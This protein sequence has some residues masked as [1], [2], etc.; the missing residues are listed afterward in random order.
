MPRSNS[1]S[2]LTKKK[3]TTQKRLCQD[4]E[5]RRFACTV[6]GCSKRFTTSGHLQRHIRTHSGERPFR[7]SVQDCTS[8]FSR[9]DNMLQ[10][11]RA[12]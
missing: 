12:H 3:K 2:T 11:Q 7:C 5:A 6:Q 1:A 9:H 10:H 8:R 4:A